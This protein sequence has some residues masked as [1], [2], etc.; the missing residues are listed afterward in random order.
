M[1]GMRVREACDRLL[2]GVPADEIAHDAG[3]ADQ[4]HM[5]RVFKAVTGMTP[6]EYRRTRR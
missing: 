5:T 6:G 2:R 1:T 4:S 3:F